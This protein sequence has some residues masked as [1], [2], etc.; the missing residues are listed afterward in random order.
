M[1]VLPL[2]IMLALL[3]GCK[4]LRETPIPIQMPLPEV[5]SPV[6]FRDLPGWLLEVDRLM[7]LNEEQLQRELQSFAD[8]SPDQPK[9]LFR[10][11]ILNQQLKDRLGW[12]R[13]R[14]SLRKLSTSDKL[15]DDLVLLV[16]LLQFHNQSMINADARKSRL[17]SAL[18]EGLQH[19]Q[20]ITEEL[21]TSRRQ[22]EQ[23]TEKIKAL[24]NL[25]KSMSI[26]RA[27][28]TDTPGESVNE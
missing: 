9:Q 11:A 4:A 1:R 26:R 22:T 16:Q 27:L 21:E 14:D 19:Q 25:E 10:Y 12:I 2:M 17:V 3:A 7:K 6:Q 24:T 8:K 18:E 28:T 5:I 13:A 20:V 23:L 15:S